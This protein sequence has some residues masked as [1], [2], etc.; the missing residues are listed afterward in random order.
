[1]CRA[2]LIKTK[3][4]LQ[5]ANSL[6]NKVCTDVFVLFQFSVLSSYFSQDQYLSV[7]KLMNVHL[8]RQT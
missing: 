3:E 1:M 8:C 6:T 7:S 4:R 5:H 2:F